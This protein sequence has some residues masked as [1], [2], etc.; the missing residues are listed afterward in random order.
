MVIDHHGVEGTTAQIGVLTK[1][2]SID[3]V[4]TALR[5]TQLPQESLILELSFLYDYLRGS[6]WRE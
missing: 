1:E 2:T 5:H 3:R 4:L 6:A